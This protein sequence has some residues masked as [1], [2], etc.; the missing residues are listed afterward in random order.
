MNK[1]F[2]NILFCLSA[3]FG[4]SQDEYRVKIKNEDKFP[5]SHVD[6][7]IIKDNKVLKELSTDE[8]GEFLVVLEKGNYII[9]IEEAGILLNSQSIYF[10][11]DKEINL[12]VT[13]Q[14]ENI[15]LGE[16]VITSQ[17][18]LVEK[19]VDRI[20]FNAD[21]AEGARGGD[22]LDLLKLAPRVK[23]ENDVISI[24][25]KS[26][27]LIMVNDRLLQI[28]GDQLI[29][30]LKSLR[31]DEIEKVEV[32]TNPPAKYQATGNSGILNIVLKNGKNDSWNGTVTST[33]GHYNKPNLRNGATFN[34]R[35]D[36][37]TI[38]SNIFQGFGQYESIGQSDIFF[39]EKNELW[40]EREIYKNNFKNIGGKLGIDYQISNKITTG[41]NADIYDGKDNIVGKTYTYV[42]AIDTSD[43]KNT[44]INDRK[45]G[46]S[47]IKYNTLNYHFIYKMDSIGKKLTV[48]FDWVNYN[49]N[50]ID[51]A[52]NRFYNNQNEENNNE[53]VGNKS[54]SD[55]KANNYSVNIDMEHPIESWKLNYGTRYSF[56]K[57]NSDNLFYDTTSG[58]PIFDLNKSNSFY[59]KEN[60]FAIYTS[61]DK[62]ITEKLSAKIGLRYENTNANGYSPQ[63]NQ[64][65]IYKY[66]G[67]FPTAYLLYKP[68]EN[69]S[70]SINFGKRIDRP[71]MSQLNPF[72]TIYS[73][74]S[75][76]QGNPELRPSYSYNYELEYGYKDLAITT[77]YY[78][79]SKSEVTQLII[80][81]EENTSQNWMPYNYANTES[82]GLS[83]NL[84]FKLFKWWKVNGSIDLFY[85]KTKGIIP[86]F[87]Y[88]LDGFNGQFGL[89]N[90]LDLNKSKT[91][92]FNH[93]T[94]FTARGNDGLDDTRSL[95]YSSLGIRTLFLN[96]KLQLSFNV[97][98]VFQNRAFQS[99]T[100]SNNNK[101]VYTGQSVRNYRIGLTYN[102]GKKFE[103]VESKSSSE[104][105]RL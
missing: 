60:I 29:N 97:N 50:K 70:L 20:I 44:I 68:S 62:E 48:D 13:S 34:Y 73:P 28:T 75:F 53:Y 84:N 55:Q 37:W 30:Y 32:I 83:E 79:K 39:K 77:L 17:K 92:L 27:L 89:T 21:M 82:Y 43:L 72:R 66:E 40:I 54:L 59:Y 86:A 94:N 81:D 101:T 7:I 87:N 9:K 57:N 100:Y 67:F 88:T 5:I 3:T 36:K 10:E 95:W 51:I 35:K 41:F 58:N 69:H 85:R 104:K 26:N 38:V 2:F 12:L 78:R 80:V 64:K 61:L 4:Y 24:I 103:I 8:K 65:D 42:R 102:F 56:T 14:N 15:F 45:G 16:T 71:S 18:K 105:N 90:N 6:I 46:N 19:K 98:N 25:G 22:A 11:N 96:K 74:Y 99:V 23:V 52:S 31:A 49:N 47:N 91:I 33:F 1:F 76:A 63:E 93:T